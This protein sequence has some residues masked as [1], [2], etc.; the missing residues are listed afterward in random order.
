MALG[1][2]TLAAAC[3]GGGDDVGA[4]GSG[5]TMTEICT[6]YCQN[7]ADHD[8]ESAVTFGSSNC[9][10]SCD[11]PCP[12]DAADEPDCQVA[13]KNFDAC[14]ADTPNVCDAQIRDDYCLDAYCTMRHACNLPDPKC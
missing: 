7:A 3:G 6:T 1:L 10:E 9:V 14:L 2:C 13:W 5:G 11:I 8:C 12:C 4:N